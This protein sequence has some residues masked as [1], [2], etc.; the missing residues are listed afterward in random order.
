M[1]EIHALDS[2]SHKMNSICETSIERYHR[3]HPII[4]L[5][6][7]ASDNLAIAPF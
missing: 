4:R 2:I 3:E 6:D 1:T 7:T 5:D